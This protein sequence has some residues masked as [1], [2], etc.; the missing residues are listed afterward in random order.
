MPTR[1]ASTSR[2]SRPAGCWKTP[3]ARIAELLGADV[4]RRQGDRLVFTSGGTEANNLAVLGIAQ[5]GAAA[6]GT[7][8][9]RAGCC[10][11]PLENCGQAPR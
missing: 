11:E 8:Q 1:P 4:D 10:D 6:N 9:S 2:G 3:A 5:A 7:D